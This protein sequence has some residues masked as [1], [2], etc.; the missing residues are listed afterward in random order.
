MKN[1]GFIPYNLVKVSYLSSS[2]T[3]VVLQLYP[4]NTYENNSYHGRFEKNSERNVDCVKGETLF[5]FPTM[6]WMACPHTAAKVA[7]LE[8]EGWIN[9][10]QEK[11]TNDNNTYDP[12]DCQRWRE[13]M[14]QAH[15]AYAE[16]R[17]GLL[18]PIDQ[19]YLIDHQC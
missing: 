19:Q 9:K 6:Y 5:P 3:A 8:E 18:T 12:N 2:G 17:W 15:R 13:Q 11:L 4:L 14:E 16:E 10:L 7:E 1:L